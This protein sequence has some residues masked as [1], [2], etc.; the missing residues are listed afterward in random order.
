MIYMY[1]SPLDSIM[2]FSDQGMCG[3]NL[4]LDMVQD[5]LLHP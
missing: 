1:Q 2:F 5:R 3:I 4:V